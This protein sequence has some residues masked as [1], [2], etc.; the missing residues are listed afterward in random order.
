MIPDRRL[1]DESATTILT[2]SLRDSPVKC[3]RAALAC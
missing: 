2:Q 3:M 1:G